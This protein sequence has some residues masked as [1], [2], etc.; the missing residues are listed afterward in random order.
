MMRHNKSLKNIDQENERSEEDSLS[1]FALSALRP[2]A[3]HNRELRF[4]I[5]IIH[6]LF[7]N[8]VFVNEIC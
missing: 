2:C 4:Q 7:D 8:D 3:L 1:I 6:E 5:I